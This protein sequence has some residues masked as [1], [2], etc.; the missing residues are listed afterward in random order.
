MPFVSSA[1]EHDKSMA[2]IQ[3]LNFISTVAHLAA[4]RQMENIEQFLTPSF[5]R[6]FKLCSKNARPQIKNC[7]KPSVKIIR[8][9]KK[10]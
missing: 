2:F 1:Q 7:L 6:R 10:Q 3:G 9:S 8:Y 5:E 4:M